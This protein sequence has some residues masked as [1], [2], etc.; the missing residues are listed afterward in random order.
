M[1][2]ITALTMTST[3]MMICIQSRKGDMPAPR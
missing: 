1:R 2:A 3:T